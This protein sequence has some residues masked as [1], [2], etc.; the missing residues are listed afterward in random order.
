MPEEAD[1]VDIKWLKADLADPASYLDVIRSFA[2]EL[3]VHLAWHGI[4]DYS[5]KISR[6]NLEQSLDLLSFV[7]E[8]GSC[9]KILVPGS[10]WELNRLTGE[11]LETE[12]G[13]PNDYFTW[14]KHALR[15]WLEVNCKRKG[16]NLGWMRFFYVYG[17][18]QRATSLIP[19]ILCAF[20]EEKIPDIRTP[21]NSNDFIFVDDVAQAI[22]LAV[23]R[24]I[25]DGI[26]NLGSGVSTPVLD[27][28]R[29]AEKIVLGSK[30]LTKKLEGKIRPGH[31]QVDFWA[32]LKRSKN[33]L[34]WT[35]T[36]SLEVGIL[37]TLEWIQQS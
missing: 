33:V 17:P 27:I 8:L 16:I 2:P 22:C 18:R 20:K 1:T 3:V 11:C 19:S 30:G 4:P 10:C 15:S 26:Y 21:G 7:A 28:C 37:R 12:T 5:F 35:P 32:D 29:I 36:T 14:A 6:A 9:R 13:T 31:R 25:P 34:G 23:N 24:K